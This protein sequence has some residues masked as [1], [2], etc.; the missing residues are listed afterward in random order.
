MQSYLQN[1]VR[2]GFIL[3]LLIL[4]LVAAASYRSAS[5]SAQ[6]FSAASRTER[7]MDML[8][9]LL[10]ALIDVETGNRGYVA[11]GSEPF[12]EPYESGLVRAQTTLEKLRL[13]FRTD[14]Q[15]QQLLKTLEPL[16]DRKIVY[17]RRLVDLRRT[18]GFQAASALL[19]D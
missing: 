15:Q 5:R 7:R 8:E 19:A 10:L 3:A 11:T 9:E 14:P 13:L 6:A 17:S 16:V 4:L 12:L 2:F 18:Q 1:K